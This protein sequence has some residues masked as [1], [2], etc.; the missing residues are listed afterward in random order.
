MC[1]FISILSSAAVPT[2]FE[3]P[4]GKVVYRVQASIDTPRFSKD[5]KTLKVFYLLNALNLNEVPNIEVRFTFRMSPYL[6]KITTL[7]VSINNQTLF[8][9]NT[10][11]LAL[12]FFFHAAAEF[13]LDKQEVQL[14]PGEDRDPDAEN[15]Q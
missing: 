1:S 14:P 11:T 4:F 9:R 10:Q 5:Y 6:L 12:R 7:V 2:S 13:R 15:L 3:G 8:L